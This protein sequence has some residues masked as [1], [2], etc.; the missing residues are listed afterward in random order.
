MIWFV[1]SFMCSVTGCTPLPD[2]GPAPTI[3]IC[4][5]VRQGIVRPVVDGV[6]PETWVEAYCIARPQQKD[7]TNG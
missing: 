5:Q 4:R 7:K 3:N 6:D 2:M 1:V